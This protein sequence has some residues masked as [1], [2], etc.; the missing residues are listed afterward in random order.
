GKPLVVSDVGWFAELPDEV[1]LKVPPGGDE[2]VDLLPAALGRVAASPAM[3]RAAKEYV[4]RE[5][6]LE[7]VAQRYA[8]ALEEA[9]GGSVVDAKVLREVADAAADTGVAP[10]LLAPRLAEL[11]LGPNG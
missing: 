1:A 9:A 10:E 5:H 11:G 3:G 8:A 7:T 6:D 2:E 4:E